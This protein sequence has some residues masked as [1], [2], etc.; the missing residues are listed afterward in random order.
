MTQPLYWL[1]LTAVATALMWM[2]Y[3]LNTIA[4]RGL[5]TAMRN[6]LP[7]AKPIAAWASR[8]KQAHNNAVENL[9]VFATLVIVAHLS[10][11]T[12]GVVGT[13]AI[14]Y[15]FA[16]LAHYTVYTLGIPM[17]RTVSFFVCF[18]AQMVIAVQILQ[19]MAA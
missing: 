9:G 15:F 5:M 6:P 16:R 14:V 13:A 12:A 19:N 17:V 11:T 3:I 2:P 1:T 8:T 18:V 4:V 7:D 10:D